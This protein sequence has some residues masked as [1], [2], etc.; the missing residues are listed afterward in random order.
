[1]S[2]IKIHRR[3]DLWHGKYDHCIRVWLHEAPC[4][5]DI[6]KDRERIRTQIQRRRDWGRRLVATMGGKQPGSWRWDSL[7]VTDVD[8]NNIMSMLDFLLAAKADYRKHILGDWM[9]FYSNDAAFIDSI[10]ALPF[11]EH[12]KMQRSRIEL[13]G[14]P[15]TVVLQESPYQYRSYFRGYMKLSDRQI[16][17]LQ[18]YLAQQEDIRMS[19]ALATWVQGSR[20]H[21]IGDYFFIDHNDMG[22]ITMLSLMVQGII[23][24]TKPIETAK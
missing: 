3:P 1:M 21:Y 24:R 23:R 16:D 10:E 5:R 7:N 6:T 8:E 11:L 17:A 12:R 19:P 13:S 20:T 9:Y 15:G 4:L 14:T 22:T 2:K 18:R